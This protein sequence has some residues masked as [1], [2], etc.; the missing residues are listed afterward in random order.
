MSLKTMKKWPRVLV[1]V[2]LLCGLFYYFYLYI[3]IK[4]SNKAVLVKTLCDSRNISQKWES[5]NFNVSRSEKLFLNLEDFFWQLYLSK[6]S[7]PYG[8]KGSELF[9]AKVLAAMTSYDMPGKIKNLPCRSCV[10]VG[11]GFV[12]KNSSLGN[13]INNYDI[14][15]RLNNA[16][17]RGYEDDVGNKTTMRL[18]YPESASFDPGLQNDPGTLMVLVPFKQKDVIWLKEI[19]Y[20]EKRTLRK[21]FWKIPPQIWL[22]KPS[23]IRI[24]D[25]YFMHQTASRVLHLPINTPAK[26]NKISSH[27]TT[28]I[29][30]IYVALNFCDVVHIAGFGYPDSKNIKYPIHYYGHD[31]MKSMKNSYHNLS[32]EAKALKRL[33][34][35]GAVVNLCRSP[36]LTKA[37]PKL[38][39]TVF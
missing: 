29:L 8:V 37:Q 28:G 5:L 21:G 13:A 14:V 30:A 38:L 24:L 15:I 22:A 20:N 9:L 35:S 1:L 19:L 12:I 3:F 31:T 7:L 4:S 10:V 27:P 16:P 6:L 33:E 18:F 34:D 11:N 32:T 25:P 36:V 39:Y 23:Q 2:L 17:V 26:R